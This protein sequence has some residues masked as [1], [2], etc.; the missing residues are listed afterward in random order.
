[1]AVKTGGS[2][3]IVVSSKYKCVTDGGSINIYPRVQRGLRSLLEDEVEDGDDL[4]SGVIEPSVTVVSD[5]G[6]SNSAAVDA[7]SDSGP[8]VVGPELRGD[9]PSELLVDEQSVSESTDSSNNNSRVNKRSEKQQE[10]LKKRRKVQKLQQKAKRVLRNQLAAEQQRVAA[11]P[12]VVEQSAAKQSEPAKQKQQ[13]RSKSSGGVDWSKWPSRE[14]RYNKRSKEET[15][16]IVACFADWSNHKDWKVY[17]SM[18]ENR[19]YCVSRQES[20]ECVYMTEDVEE[21]YR[22]VTKG[23]PRTFSE[24]LVDPVWGRPAREEWE[25]LVD[26][27]A[28]VEIDIRIAEEAIKNGADLVTLFPIYEE[29]EKEGVDVKKTRLLGDGRTQYNAGS[30]YAPTPSR[31]ELM[32]LLHVCASRGW[33]LIHIDEVRAFLNATYK[34]DQKVFA[35][36]KGDTR[37]YE[38]LKALYGLKTSPRDYN[39]EV[40]GRLEKLGFQALLISAQVFILRDL[41]TKALL[42]IFDWVDDFVIFT[43]SAKAALRFID[44]FRAMTTTTE[45]VWNP[46][47][48]LGMELERDLQ[49]GIIMVSMKKKIMELAEEYQLHGSKVRHVPIPQSGYVIKDAD[50]EKMSAEAA[51]FLGI[52]EIKVYLRIVGSLVWLVPVRMDVMFAVTYLTWFTRAPRRH[53][54]QMAL[55]VL[56]YLYHSMDVPLVLGGK[57]K[58]QVETSSDASLGTA[59]KGRSVLSQFTRLGAGAGGVYAKSSASSVVSLASFEA[60]LEACTRAIKTL[61]YITNFFTE[62]NIEVEKPMLRCDNE[63]MV[64]FVMGET[65]ANGARHVELKQWFTREQYKMNHFT[66]KW[67]SGKEI[68]ADKFTKLADH[69]KQQEFRYDVQGLA[70]LNTNSVPNEL[71]VDDYDG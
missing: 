64:N 23:V 65:T 26:S 66:L 59:P 45:P 46:T 47:K 15:E 67:Q 19:L 20:G 70:L 53:H 38:V 41:E 4:Q 27:K 56:E 51:E 6:D 39:H 57:G 55:H 32:I 9:Q 31:E 12:F 8:V 11:E 36:L 21:G 29:K 7:V 49:K 1:M 54:L 40:K 5:N 16:K 34:G 43:D 14:Q 28:L 22:A 58:L 63:A 13:Q 52:K 33:E 30:T 25:K 10:K 37:Y 35:K 2:V 24:A 60:E 61:L 71:P 3:Q 44:T 48:L 68:S 18:T 69:L 62:L 42:V 17:I 50:F